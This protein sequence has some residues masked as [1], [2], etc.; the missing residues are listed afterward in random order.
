MALVS[1]WQ[2]GLAHFCA[3]LGIGDLLDHVIASA[4]IGFAKPEPE[5]FHEACRRL[6]VP[7]ERTLHVGDSIVDDLEGARHAGLQAV[8]VKRRPDRDETS[9]SIPDLRSVLDVCVPGA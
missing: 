5:I 6:G 9:P 7:P 1:N 4:E 3:D 2:C 8:L